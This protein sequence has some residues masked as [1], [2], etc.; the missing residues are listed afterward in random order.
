MKNKLTF[1]VSLIFGIPFILMTDLF[2]LHRYGM[3]ASLPG[4]PSIKKKY[5]IEIFLKG[6]WQVLT[7]GNE[8]LDHGYF[9]VQA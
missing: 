2:P 3:F 9:P 7:S 5:E 8:Y 6:T 4:N 1:L